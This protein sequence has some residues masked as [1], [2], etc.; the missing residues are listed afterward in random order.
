[1]DLIKELQDAG[2]MKEDL[3]KLQESID[4]KDSDLFDVLEYIAYAK[5]PVTRVARVETGKENIFTSLQGNEKEFVEHV[6][7]NYIDYGVDELS[8][9]K[10][11]TIL[12]AK[13]GGITSAQ[14]R[15]G[16]LDDIKSTFINFQKNLYNI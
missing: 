7:N 9:N 15:L 5:E 6:L 8:I 14:S 12:T 11:S 3:E 2:C 16:S 10:L 13:Y 1:M 4:A